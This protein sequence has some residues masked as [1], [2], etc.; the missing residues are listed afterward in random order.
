MRAAITAIEF[1]LPDQVL[2]NDDLAAEFPEWPIGKIFDKTGIEARHIAAPGETASD[3]ARQAALK[4]FASGAAKADEI[5][6][7]ILCTQAPDYFLPTT[8]CIL[9]DALGIPTTT[10]ALDINLGCSG[11]VYGLGLAKALVETGQAR[12]VLL[13]TADTYSRFIHP[14][15][16]SVRSL[17]G[18]GAAATLIRAVPRS[19][20]PIDALIYGTDGKGAKNLIVTT[21]GARQARTPETASVSQDSNGNLRA[22]DNLYMNGQEIF[23]FTLRAVPKLVRDVLAKADVRLDSVSH[24]V[25]H[26]ANAYMLEAIRKKL[27]IP[28][29]RFCVMVRH[30]GNTVS[31][32]IPIALKTLVQSG[33]LKAGETVL[34][35]GFGVGYS[36]AGAMLIWDEDFHG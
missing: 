2:T 9:Q 16:K 3:L 35:A 29:E 27:E 33:K 25:M 15:D 1:H 6:F 36:W 23:T 4:L 32:T 14:G 10:G 18:D 8:A 11:F 26:Q 31:S 12:A 17:F 28:T 21:G 24:F 34:I 7:L 20:Q 13:L 5:D 19:L 22:P 30:C